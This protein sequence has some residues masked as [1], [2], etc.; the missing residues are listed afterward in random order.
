[1]VQLTVC[2]NVPL[3]GGAK[4]GAGIWGERNPA[5]G[6]GFG[7]VIFVLGLN[8]GFDPKQPFS[9]VQKSTMLLKNTVFGAEP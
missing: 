2:A 5:I 4:C 9:I 1:L 6:L 8:D 3:Q 7:P